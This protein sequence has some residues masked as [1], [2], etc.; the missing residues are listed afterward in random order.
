V[1]GV[2][3]SVGREFRVKNEADEAAFQAAIDGV[4]K[5]FGHVRIHMRLIVSIDQIQKPS[6]VVREAAAIGEIAHVTDARPGI[7]RDI[8]IRR[9]KPARIRQAQEIF[10][11]DR[12]PA[13]HDWLRNRVA[14][15][16]SLGSTDGPDGEKRDNGKRHPC[17][18]EFS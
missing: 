2:K 12:Q 18:H 4:R 1:H 10:D 6:R 8:L 7:R 13:L 17:A 14:G 11:F 15:D 16:L 9:T 3:Q 5:S